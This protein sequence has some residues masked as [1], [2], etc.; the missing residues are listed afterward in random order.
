MDGCLIDRVKVCKFLG[1]QIDERL[2]WKCHINYVLTKLA[3]TLGMMY[4]ARKYVNGK[5]LE[6]IYNSLFLP[7][8]DYCAEIWGNTYNT[9]LQKIIT[10]QKKATR[11]IGRVGR[12]EHTESLFDKLKI[13]KFCDLVKL[14]TLSVMHAAFNYRLPETTKNILI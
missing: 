7:Y 8:L 5:T 2:N 13:L 12:S 14:K 1:V 9:N 4:H 11:L 6:I 3:K 10:C